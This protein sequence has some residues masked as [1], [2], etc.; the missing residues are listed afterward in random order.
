MGKITLRDLTI[1]AYHGCFAEETKIGAEYRLDVWV[2]GDFCS[3]EKT[4]DLSDTVDY[5][6]LSDIVNEE[7]SIPSKLIEHVADRIISKILLV[8]PSIQLAGLAIKKPNPPM[9]V[10][11]DYVEYKLERK[12][13]Q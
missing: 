9:N 4:D 11:A 6:Q 13:E 1:Y 10:Y 3:A 12:R 5:V 8:F 7:M 2:E